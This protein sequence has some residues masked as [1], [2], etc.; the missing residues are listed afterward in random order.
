MQFLKIWIVPKITKLFVKMTDFQRIMIS[1]W[2]PEL[3]YENKN[4]DGY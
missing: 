1:K 3:A 2:Y 4:I